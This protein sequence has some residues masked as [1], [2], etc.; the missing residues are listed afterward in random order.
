[1]SA[2]EQSPDRATRQA[3]PHDVIGVGVAFSAAGLYFMLGAAGYLPTPETNSPLGHR[4]LRRVRVPVQ[5]LTCLVR[6]RAGI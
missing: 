2:Q 6:V 3:S 5:G 4:V 1:M